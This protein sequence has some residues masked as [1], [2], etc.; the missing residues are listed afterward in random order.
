[1]AGLHRVREELRTERA[2]AQIDL[3][4]LAILK[5][6]SQMHEL[7]W[8]LPFE[9]KC[10]A[11]LQFRDRPCH[12]PGVAERT[13]SAIAALRRLATKRDYWRRAISYKG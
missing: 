12:A 1:M 6:R 4:V 2:T 10:M 8:D 3:V 11:H 13:P 9:E 5:G 7:V